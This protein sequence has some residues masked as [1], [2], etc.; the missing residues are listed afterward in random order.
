MSRSFALLIAVPA[1][2]M[3]CAPATQISAQPQPTPAQAC[4]LQAASIEVNPAVN[5]TDRCFAQQAAMSDMFEIQSSKLALQRSTNADV[6]AFADQIIKDHTDASNKLKDRAGKLNIA[7]PT[8]LDAAKLADLQ[9]L[10]VKQ[11]AAFDRVYVA[12]QINAHNDAI[13]LF[14]GYLGQTGTN[15][16][17]RTHADETLPYLTH[18][19]EMARGLSAKVQ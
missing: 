10:Q 9:A 5:Q 13:E 17:L 6:K 7:L 1:L 19:L 16:T 3:S 18:H 2:L 14:K 11:G 15:G 8:T 4:G 12:A